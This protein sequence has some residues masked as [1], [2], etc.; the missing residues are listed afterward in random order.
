MKIQ[1]LAIIFLIIAIPIFMVLSYN[2]NLQMQTIRK[3]I[4]YDTSFLGATKDTLKAVETNL[5]DMS[6]YSRSQ[7][8]ENSYVKA[9]VNTFLTGIANSTNVVGNAKEYMANHVPALSFLM[10]DGYYMYSKEKIPVA[11]ENKDTGLQLFYDET[12]DIIV[13]LKNNNPCLPIYEPADSAT[14]MLKTYTYKDKDLNDVTKTIKFVTDPDKAKQQY[15]PQ[16]SNKKEYSSR[17]INSSIKTDVTVGFT[18]DN[19]ISLYGKVEDSDVKAQG[20]LVWFN[21]D[22]QFPILD[23]SYNPISSYMIYNG[24]NIEPE[25]LSEQI[26]YTDNSTTYIGTYKYFYDI[27]HRK[28]YYDENI[29]KF[30]IK[31]KDDKRTFLE[32][33]SHI[34]AGSE[35]CY[36][37]SVSVLLGDNNATEEFKK[38]YKVINGADKGK[39]FVCSEPDDLYNAT[40]DIKTLDYEIDASVI[41]SL[42]ISIEP[43][44]DYSA[45]NYYVEARA[46]TNF[47]MQNLQ[48]VEELTYNTVTDAYETTSINNIFNIS[49]N[50]NPEDK[51]SPISQYKQTLMREKI[52]EDL[53]Y[54]I[55]NFSRGNNTTRIPKIKD[56]DWEKAF[57]NI[58]VIAF[59]QEIPIGLKEYNN[60][61]L[62]TSKTNQLFV[63]T[64]NFYFSGNDEYF[65]RIYCENMNSVGDYTGYRSIEYDVKTMKTDS[66]NLYYYQHDT[67]TNGT[68]MFDINAEKACY[69][70]IIN[71]SKFGQT[72]NWDLINSLTKAYEEALARER[73][74]SS[75]KL[76]VGDFDFENPDDDEYDEDEGDVEEDEYDEEEYEEDI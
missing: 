30:F 1:N 41:Q 61:F 63:D 75:E 62:V 19:K 3:Q 39:W 45:I 16:L 69:N 4:E 49:E 44:V 72:T 48:N 2:M 60:Y 59:L 71:R 42:G 51:Y 47:I 18:L 32:D 64:E 73:Y 36:Y 56:T 46:F 58:S 40:G 34:R 28:V 8:P 68:S 67:Y 38:I 50:N 70:C 26:T 54:A 24:V 6:S 13:D 74:R 25:E 22:S 10:Y 12:Q 35:G 29:N 14:G 37:K 57:D 33:Y 66:G 5:F 55:Y 17:Y 27:S 7:I 31:D 65:H 53:N 20:H 9:G 76:I 43:F 21:N 15:K 11:L 52:E 23:S